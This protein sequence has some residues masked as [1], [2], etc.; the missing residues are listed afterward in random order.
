[1]QLSFNRCTTVLHLYNCLYVYFLVLKQ[2]PSQTDQ[3]RGRGHSRSH[4]CVPNR[5]GQDPL[6]EP[7]QRAASLQEHVRI[8]KEMIADSSLT[9]F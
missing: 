6:T 7:T 5:P 9:P 4:L 1:M 3:W 8:S 2:P